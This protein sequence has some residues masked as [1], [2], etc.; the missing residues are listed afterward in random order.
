[1]FLHSSAI[2]LTI[3]LASRLDQ[4]RLNVAKWEG[5]VPSRAPSLV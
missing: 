4:I 5:G 1:M 2:L 3:L